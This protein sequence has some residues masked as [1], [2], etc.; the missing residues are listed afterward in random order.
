MTLLDLHLGRPLTRGA[1]T[2]FPVWDGHAVPDRGYDLGGEHVTVAERAGHAV[3]AELVALQHR[4][5]AGAG[6]GGRTV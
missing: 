3:V 1:L 5:Q 4:L 2:I 6:V